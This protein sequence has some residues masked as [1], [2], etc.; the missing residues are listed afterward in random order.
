M[1][2]SFNTKEL[3]RNCINSIYASTKNIDYEIIVID[4]ASNDG[5]PQMIETEFRDIKLI[6]NRDNLGFAK[7]NNQAIAVAQGKYLLLLNS[8]TIIQKGS[9]ER[10]VDFLSA[11]PKVAAVG[12]KV[13]NM[14]G[15]LQSKG[16]P[17]SPIRGKILHSLSINKLP[18]KL[19]KKMFGKYFWSADEF[20]QVLW[21]SG[22]CML[23][24][25]AVVKEIGGLCEEFLFYCEDTEWCYRAGK[26]KYE[27]WYVPTAVITHIGGG[28]TSNALNSRLL[29]EN[30]KLLC[31]KT[32][33]VRRAFFASSIIIIIKS[34]KYLGLYFI[35]KKGTHFELLSRELKW[36]F[37]I[38]KCF[39]S[40]I[41][42][43]KK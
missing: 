36:E 24:K 16:F 37:D 26:A 19:K 13:L 38:L 39:V 28:S 12:P 2:I 32:I 11:H 6:K 40:E 9:I 15:S 23:V 35:N 10:L 27:I 31:N 33:G 8:D 43:F 30:Y 5:S 41:I 3:L 20:A 18:E 4:N 25:H 14:D 34:I 7:A 1:I 29:T 17:L 21:I 42:F 22:C